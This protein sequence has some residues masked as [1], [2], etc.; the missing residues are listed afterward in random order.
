MNVVYYRIVLLQFI[1][2][3]FLTL[4]SCLNLLRLLQKQGAPRGDVEL[5]VVKPLP[6]P[7]IA[8][9]DNNEVYLA[10]FYLRFIL[11]VIYL[12]LICN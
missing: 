11:Y 4:N 9:S 10:V 1:I 12:F 8:D 7:E 3:N 2:L 6:L 5:C